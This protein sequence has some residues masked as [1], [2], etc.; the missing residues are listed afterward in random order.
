MSTLLPVSLVNSC[1]FSGMSTIHPVSA[2]RVSTPSKDRS[3][4]LFYRPS[5]VYKSFSNYL[6]LYNL[7]GDPINEVRKV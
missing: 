5:V 6:F 2:H 4:V 1:N 3:R 7:L